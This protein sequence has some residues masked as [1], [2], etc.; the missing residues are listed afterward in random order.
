MASVKWLETPEAHDFPAASDYLDLLADPPTVKKLAKRLRTG[1]VTHK[2][3]KD[4]LRAAQLS[5]LPADNP[6]SPP[7]SPRL[8]KALRCRPSC[9]CV[10]T[11]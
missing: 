7:I 4:I 2:K 10:V 9:W 6:T 11:S 8:S 5:L 1:T 3:A